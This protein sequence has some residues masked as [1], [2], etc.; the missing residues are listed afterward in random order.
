MHWHS[1]GPPRLGAAYVVK[2][3]NYA[4]IP[5]L[6]KLA[7]NVSCIIT[8]TERLNVQTTMDV[9]PSV[10]QI[11]RPPEPEV[12]CLWMDTQ[13]TAMPDESHNSIG[14]FT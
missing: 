11:T 12:R 13:R 3:Y 2:A 7:L 1:R 6:W 5:S 8:D 10:R 9:L 4:S 14:P